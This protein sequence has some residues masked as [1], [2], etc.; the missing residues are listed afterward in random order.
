MK[1][2]RFGTSTPRYHPTSGPTY[3]ETGGTPVNKLNGSFGLDMCNGCINIFWNNITTEQETAC[4]IFS[5]SGVALDHLICWIKTSSGYF[6]NRQLFMVSF[7]R[8]NDWCICCKW[9][10]NSRIRNEIGL[11]FSQINIQSSVES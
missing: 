7:F 10:M 8:R 3:L 4:H 6:A 2:C 1:K 5:M 11:K 9:K